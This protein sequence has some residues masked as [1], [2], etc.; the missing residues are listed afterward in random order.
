MSK[1]LI[2]NSGK[3][4]EIPLDSSPHCASEQTK[5]GKKPCENLENS[6]KFTTTPIFK[7][8]NLRIDKPWINDYFTC[9]SIIIEH[10]N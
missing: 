3:F 5:C 8:E 4:I 2:K 6:I 7:P 1:G 9:T 10:G